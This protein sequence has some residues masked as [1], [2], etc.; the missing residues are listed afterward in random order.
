MPYSPH[1]TPTPDS[2][3]PCRHVTLPTARRQRSGRQR[4][5][6]RGPLD[7]DELAAASAAHPR[8]LGMLLAL[9]YRRDVTGKDWVTPPAKVLEGFGLD[10]SA[11]SRV[12]KALEAAGL[13]EVQRRPG[14]PPLVRLRPRDPA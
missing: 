4:P 7:L 3:I 14:R 9:R 10:R 12:L 1:Q 5:F 8:G 2:A 13:V 6:V 11:R